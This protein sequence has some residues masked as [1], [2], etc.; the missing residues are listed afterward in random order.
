MRGGEEKRGN[1]MEK[2]TEGGIRVGYMEEEILG[3]RDAVDRCHIK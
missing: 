3:Q 2:C 1:E